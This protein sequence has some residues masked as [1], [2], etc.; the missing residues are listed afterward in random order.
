MLAKNRLFVAGATVAL[1]CAAGAAM[2]TGPILATGVTDAASLPV[3][4]GA[5]LPSGTALGHPNTVIGSVSIDTPQTATI[6]ASV[7][8][9]ILHLKAPG[10][11]GANCR[12]ILDRYHIGNDGEAAEGGNV[13]GGNVSPVASLA[14]SASWSD[15]AAGHHTVEM[16]C[17]PLI[18][19]TG[20]EVQLEQ[21][22]LNVWAVG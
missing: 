3:G 4:A 5:D 1:I 7:S 19:I 17:A 14:I 9:Y 11:S 21:P 12:L 6:M 15:V 13:P 2:L 18:P 8:A 20:Y 16:E 10:Y 22:H